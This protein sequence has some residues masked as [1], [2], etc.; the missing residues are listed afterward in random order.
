M[1]EGGP[2]TNREE[3]L[4]EKELTQE[5]LEGLLEVQISRGTTWN[6]IKKN[7]ELMVWLRF[8][9][10]KDF[11]VYI[12][13][14]SDHYGIMENNGIKSNDCFIDNGLLR[15]DSDGSLIFSYQSSPMS[16]IHMAAETKIMKFFENRGIKLN[17]EKKHAHAYD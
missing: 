14:S 16:I 13:T 4:K 12:D 1:K 10:T 11:D 5:E 2:K 8:I 9:V 17:K 6:N 15:D 7:M 3:L